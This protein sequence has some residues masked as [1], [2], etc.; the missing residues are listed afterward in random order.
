MASWGLHLGR[1]QVPS[2]QGEKQVQ[3]DEAF[4]W[5]GT[6]DLMSSQGASMLGSAKVKAKY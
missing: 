4:S 5:H 2:S 6:G 1:M 3:E